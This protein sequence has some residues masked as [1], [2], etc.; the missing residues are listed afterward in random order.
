MVLLPVGAAL[1][2]VVLLGESFGTAH[3]LALGLA[4]VGLLLATWPERRQAAGTA[5]APP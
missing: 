5:A 4:L 1:V 2:G 3:V